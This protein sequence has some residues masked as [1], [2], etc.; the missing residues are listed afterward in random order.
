MEPLDR[1][2]SLRKIGL[3]TEGIGPEMEWD[4]TSSGVHQRRHASFWVAIAPLLIDA[5]GD[6]DDADDDDLPHWMSERATALLR[7]N[8]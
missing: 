2:I 5:Y 6:D 8:D 3:C 4:P 1:M 7:A